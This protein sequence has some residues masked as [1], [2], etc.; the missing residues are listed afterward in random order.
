MV[1]RSQVVKGLM[2]PWHKS[3][4]NITT[5]NFFTSVPL[6]EKLLK[7]GLMYFCI[8][9]SIIPHIP[10]MMKA[11]Y[12]RQIYSSLF[13]FRGLL[14]LVSYIPSPGLAVLELSTKHHDTKVEGKHQKP[15]IVQHYN[16]TKSDVANLDKLATM[17]TSRRKTSRWP[18][19]L[20]FNLID[21]V[22]AFAA[23]IIWMGNFPSWKSS[24]G[25]GRHQTFLR[26]LG[27]AL[28][29]QSIIKRRAQTPTLN[30]NHS[31]QANHGPKALLLVLWGGHFPLFWRSRALFLLYPLNVKDVAS[32]TATMTR[33]W[34]VC[35]SCQVANVPQARCY[36]DCVPSLPVL[37]ACRTRLFC[38]MLGLINVLAI[39]MKSF[40]G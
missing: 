37:H 27:H 28:V 17:Y 4:R 12:G 21:V 22:A 9:R 34:H 7:D 31:C 14:T 3:G 1:L 33:R 5:D 18:M 40:E 32:V 23:F 30:T 2:A 39:C 6:A 10:E 29:M 24:E 16:A 36:S 20:L 13:G 26:E 35:V 15:E 11:H 19:V 8:V 25:S 38:D